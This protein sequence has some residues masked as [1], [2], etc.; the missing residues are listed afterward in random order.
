[1]LALHTSSNGSFASQ[2]QSEDRSVAR[3][4]PLRYL[5]IS[6]VF[7]ATVFSSVST[8]LAQ[9][10]PIALRSDTELS[11]ANKA[12]YQRVVNL[13]KAARLVKL[14]SDSRSDVGLNPVL[15]NPCW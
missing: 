15:F 4:R 3:I 10:R 7:A 5:L 8:S 9:D 13:Y 2:P 14:G 6:I 11:A 12:E 1:M